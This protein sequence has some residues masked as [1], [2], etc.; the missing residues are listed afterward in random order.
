MLED[1]IPSEDVIVGSLQSLDSKA[2][3]ESLN[4]A[5]VLITLEEGI[6]VAGF[7]FEL[8]SKLLSYVWG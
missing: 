4:R 5:G 1:E 2:V 3:K 8:I 7:G 6:F